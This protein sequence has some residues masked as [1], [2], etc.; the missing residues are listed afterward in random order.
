MIHQSVK[1]NE[2]KI[3]SVKLLMEAENWQVDENSIAVVIYF[4]AE[5]L[6]DKLVINAFSGLLN[7]LVCEGEEH[8]KLRRCDLC[9]R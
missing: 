9:V 8:M 1:S 7:C 4:H 3:A 5:S 6:S 2:H